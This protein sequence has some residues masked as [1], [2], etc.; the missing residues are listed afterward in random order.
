MRDTEANFGNHYTEQFEKPDRER[1]SHMRRGNYD[2]L[3]EDG[4]LAPGVAVAEDDA[5]TGKTAANLTDDPQFTKRDHSQFNRSFKHGIVDSVL[6]T[7]NEQGF[8]TVKTKIR[9]IR[10]P[11]IGD[12][13]SAP[14]GQKGVIGRLVPPEELPFA[15]KDGLIPDIIINPHAYP[16]RMTIGM[17]L[18]LLAGK[19]AVITGK[20]PDAT[21][22]EKCNL[23]D[24]ELTTQQELEELLMQAG[25]E[26]HGMEAFVNPFTGREFHANFYVGLSY[27]QRL[28]HMVDDKLHARSTGPKHIVTR[29]PIDGRSRDGGLRFGEMGIFFLTLCHPN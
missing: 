10:V 19:Q 2:K 27:Y 12:K 29:Q 4:L 20:R 28:K 25:L 1:C 18:E 16:G 15:V 11:Q 3:E 23:E 6:I 13:F 24:H 17:V 21:A 9:S 14:H 26:K 22:F 5:V 8:R 7:S